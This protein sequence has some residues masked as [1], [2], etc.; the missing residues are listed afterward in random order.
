[1]ANS[2][3][4]LSKILRQLSVTTGRFSWWMRNDEFREEVENLLCKEIGRES[5]LISDVEREILEKYKKDAEEL[6]KLVTENSRGVKRP[7][8]L[9]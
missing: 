4:G 8:Y 3:G 6:R 9:I 1:M 5:E 2:R 7:D